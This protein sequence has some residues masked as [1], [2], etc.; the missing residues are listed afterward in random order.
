VTGETTAA[1]AIKEP[2]RKIDQ[3][4]TIVHL[5][6]KAVKEQATAT[7]VLQQQQ[8]N[9]NDEITWATVVSVRRHRNK[10]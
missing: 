6:L 3:G 4:S 10:V 8:P 7:D 1:A 5:Q 9:M 2:F